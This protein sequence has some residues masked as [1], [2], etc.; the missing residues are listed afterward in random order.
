MNYEITKDLIEAITPYIVSDNITISDNDMNWKGE[1]YHSD[2]V[3]VDQK[4][5][6]GFEVFANEII[7]FYF[8][9]HCHFENYSC[10]CSDIEN[11][12]I[13][14]A[15][16][17][18]TEL[19]TLPMRHVET[20]RG[21]KL[22]SEKYYIIHSDGREESNTGVIYH[23][24]IGL[25]NP[26][27]KKSIAITTWQYDKSKG[28]FTNSQ[29]K[30]YDPKAI[31]VI[32]VNDSCY[33]EIFEREGAFFFEIQKLYFDDYYGMYYWA[34]IYDKTLSLFVTKEKAINA[35]KENL[36]NTYFNTLQRTI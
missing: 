22:I 30:I 8:T 25:I 28:M 18:L 31:E 12:Y 26:F 23:S 24:I 16:K 15:Q 4:N 20:Y 9:D 36:K 1:M 17:F 7:V 27:V 13:K 34:P 32:T 5:H 33:I 11:D 21:K 14:L 3:M 2:L 10:D 29:P 6:V 35:A 19:F